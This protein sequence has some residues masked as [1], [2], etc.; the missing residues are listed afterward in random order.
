ML[1]WPHIVE[2]LPFVKLTTDGSNSP[3]IE[4][5]WTR[6]VEMI[7]IAVVTGVMSTYSATMVLSAQISDLKVRVEDLQKQIDII[8]G[9]T[10]YR[11]PGSYYQRKR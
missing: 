6:V 9:N 8:Q 3:Q 11:I 2:Y 1:D 5:R 4:V 10:M 7:I